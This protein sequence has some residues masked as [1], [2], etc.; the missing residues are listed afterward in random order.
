[1]ARHLNYNPAHDSVRYLDAI[2]C[3][4][5]RLHILDQL[6]IALRAEIGRPNHQHHL[7]IGPRGS[8]KTHMLR[9]LTAGRIPA[10]TVLAAAYLPIV[11]PEETPLRS[12]ADLFL[13]FVE[14]LAGLLKEPPDGLAPETARNARS[15]CL[16]GLAEAKGVRDPKDRLD[17][18]ARILKEAAAVLGRTLL[19]VAENMDQTL[20]L[21]SQRSRKGPIEE[22][23][24][25]RR[26]L[27]ST[28]HLLL[29]GAAPSTFGAV[30]DPGKPFYDFFRT[31]ELREL[32]NDEVFEIIR[33]RLEYEAANPS[34]DAARAVR[35]ECLNR[36]IRQEESKVR[37]LLAITGG[38]PRF[39]HLVYEVVV[40]TDVRKVMD[41]LNGF[42]DEM[43]PYFQQRLDPRFIPQPEVDL[44]H[45][46]AL[47]RGPQQPTELADRLYGVQTNEVSEL[48]GRLE[49]RG[50]VKRAG[51]PGGRAVTWDLS[52]P[53]YRVW[54]QFRDNPANQEQYRLL[55]EFVALLFSRDEIE[56]E[57]DWLCEKISCLADDPCGREGLL[58]RKQLMDKAY[59][60]HKHP[61]ATLECDESS[62][63][64]A[65]SSVAKEAGTLVTLLNDAGE[66]R[67]QQ[68]CEAL[69]Q[70][71][72]ALSRSWPK[73][74][75]VR[76]QLAMGLFNSFYDAGEEGDRQR[77]EALL[78]ELR[79]LSRSWPE[80]GAVREQLARGLVNWLNYAW[81]Q[82]DRQRC[83]GLIEELRTVSRSWPEDGAVRE[84]LAKGLFNSLYYARKE[85]DRQRCEG[86]LE[87][88]RALSHAWPEDGATRVQLAMGLFNSLNDAGEGEDRQRC[89]GLLQ[90]LRALSHAWPEDGAV[91]E[92]LAKGLFNSFYDAGKE[93]DRQRRKGLLEELRTLSHTWPEDRAVRE[94]LAMGLFNS[95]NDARKEGD[96]DQCEGLLEELRAL[97]RS[98]LEDGAVRGQLAK[99]LLNSL[100]DAVKGGDH[101]R[102]EGLLEELRALSRT[103]PEDGAVRERLAVGLFNSLNDA[104]Q[105]ED[106][107]RCEGLL[108]ELRAISRSWPEDG[109]VR[110]P[111]AM[112][113][114][115]SLND[116]RKEGDL[117]R[118]EGLL[119]ELLALGDSSSGEVIGQAVERGSMIFCHYL[120][121]RMKSGEAESARAGLRWLDSRMPA[122]LADLLRPATLAMEVLE[123]G[124]EQALAREPEE[125]RRAVRML[126]EILD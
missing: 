6:V 26:H 33:L 60:F 45:T 80:D 12:P 91:R 54:T 58:A 67:D 27:S 102:C 16:S 39:T 110:E 93:G 88:L 116:A 95:L 9:L 68:R 75:A 65:I 111:L 122:H 82:G 17:V 105:E 74:G 101:K 34:S 24:A 31:H 87:E 37:G 22:H 114:F 43:T 103:W 53:L 29:I 123:K 85:G 42:L 18:M 104:R 106:R 89:E 4:E 61:K 20:Y 118:C 55:A 124:A 47:A 15:I 50:L 79:A 41:T 49:E 73:D 19:P 97:S 71:L 30:G 112:G 113:L 108:E 76:E 1:M 92:Q 23:W 52:E 126:L 66:E 117:Q 38:L 14:R 25:L 90:E 3:G 46:L 107:Q 69:L 13:K 62:F 96:R 35:I 40:D 70:E 77:C 32:S 121:I 56:K 86:L 115:N 64:E 83:E 99:G 51:R 8:G 7:L 78:Q 57:R 120:L 36:R 28:P 109:A 100:Y 72:R 21:G 59:E 10:D 119:V 125:V 98:W 94:P 84:P 5:N 11:M 2:T 63:A 48:L 81:E 44:L